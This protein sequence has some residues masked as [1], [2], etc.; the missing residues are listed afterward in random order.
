MLARN[1]YTPT[2]PPSLSARN[3]TV[4]YCNLLYCTIESLDSTYTINLDA[5]FALFNRSKKAFL[6]QTKRIIRP[7]STVVPPPLR[8]NFV[9]KESQIFRPMRQHGINAGKAG[10]SC[11]PLCH[12]ALDGMDRPSSQP[13]GLPFYRPHL[14][15]FLPSGL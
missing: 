11:S 4:L 15:T 6:K 8:F 10:R 13:P 14:P 12:S 3:R 1:G 5:L 2:H 9:A 7:W